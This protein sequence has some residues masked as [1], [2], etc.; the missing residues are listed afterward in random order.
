M[1]DTGKAKTRVILFSIA[2]RIAAVFLKRELYEMILPDLQEPATARSQNLHTSSSRAPYSVSVTL[3]YV[4]DGSAKLTHSVL[5]TVPA[6]F[7]IVNYLRGYR[8]KARR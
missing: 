2:R 4:Y 8:L 3:K 1:I 6:N 7:S 5:L